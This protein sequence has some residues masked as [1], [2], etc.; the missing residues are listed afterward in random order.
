MLNYKHTLLYGMYQ[1]D[2]LVS[3]INLHECKSLCLNDPLCIAATFANDGTARCFKKKTLYVSGYADPCLS[4]V[5][6]VKMCSYPMAVNPI[7]VISSSQV[8]PRKGCGVFESHGNL[9]C[10]NVV[11]DE[12]FEAKVSEFGLYRIA[13]EMSRYGSS[14]K[15]D[16]KDF[17]KIVLTLI[18][19]CKGVG[20]LSHWAYKEWTEENAL[21]VVDRK[22]N[23]RV[24]SKRLDR[25]LR[26]T[27]WCLLMDE[28]MRP[29]MREV[30]KVLEG[31]LSVDSPPPSFTSQRLPEE[32]ESSE[33][34]Q[35]RPAHFD[36]TFIG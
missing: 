7:L 27:F 36:A 23:S 24:D 8:T 34:R 10:E 9:K 18:S 29:S 11:L 15:M 28:R 32:E 33:T 31:T 3:R 4:S 14:A 35:T 13:S 5:S 21:N 30:V 16:V 6:L 2:D 1:N 25:V 19:G 20:D 22:I 17:G 12:N 26:I